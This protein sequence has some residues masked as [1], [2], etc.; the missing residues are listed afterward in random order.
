VLYGDYHTHTLYSHGKGTIEQNVAAARERGL[1]EIAITDHGFR[2]MIHGGKRRRL[3]KIKEEIDALNAKYPDIKILFGVEANM[4]GRDGTIDIRPE[5]REIFDIVLC[6]YHVSVWAKNPWQQ[7]SFIA[8]NFFSQFLWGYG[9]GNVR[10]N[11]KAYVNMI[12]KNPVAALT[13]INFR[14]KA[15]VV[16]VAKAARDNGTFIEISGKRTG[17]TDREIEAM[18]ATGVQFIVNS[19]AHSPVKVGGVQFALDIIDRVGIPYTQ[20]ANWEKQP[21]LRR[22]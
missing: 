16:E 20:I 15:D 21:V 4:T 9:K 22:R 3:G 17:C 12:E 14:I 7:V 19:D 10:K 11:T 1:R 5:E 8:R 13:H 18:A 6:G 2:N